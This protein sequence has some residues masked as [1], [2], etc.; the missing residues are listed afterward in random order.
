M[1]VIDI[2]HCNSDFILIFH[3]NVVLIGSKIIFKR[4]ICFAEY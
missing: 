3:M 1:E 4:A 2:S